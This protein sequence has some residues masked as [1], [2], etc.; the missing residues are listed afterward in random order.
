L[1]DRP[2]E[3]ADR[4]LELFENPEQGAEMAARARA[5]VEAHWAMAA[6]T[7]RLVESYQE[8]VRE[9]RGAKTPPASKTPP[10]ETGGGTATS[11]S[12]RA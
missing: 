3:F 12:D 7:R 2:A 6:I 10:A 11:F 4:V 1:A 9:K 8:A 5:E